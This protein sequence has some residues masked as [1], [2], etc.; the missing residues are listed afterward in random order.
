MCGIFGIVYNDATSVPDEA[1]LRRSAGLLAHRGP[2]GSGVHVEAGIGLAHTR[3][4]LVSLT[5]RSNQPFWDPER[6]YCLIYNGE[7]YN[8]R[9]LRG[10]LR[11]RGVV[12]RTT[13]D[14]EVLLQCLIADG[15]E[16]T[17]PRLHGMFAFAFYDTVTRRV[18]L[19]R[20]RFGI[21]PLH[22]YQ[23]SRQL[24]VASEMKAMMPWI[25]LRPDVFQVV[26]YLMNRGAP[27]RNSGFLEHVQIMPPGTMITLRPGEQPH[28]STFADLPGM[29]DRARADALES[30]SADRDRQCSRSAVR[31]CARR[32]RLRFVTVC[33]CSVGNR[34]AL[35]S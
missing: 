17:L 22:V 2:D 26:R 21:K 31:P 8:F 28:Y 34:A 3:L 32:S 30:L 27:V 25:A 16:L 33:G 29:L 10:S 7:I 6:R 1:R 20:D 19:A 24:L 11:A 13:S 15:A 4:S 14:T 18:V 35:C 12:F 5:E 9:E 23:D